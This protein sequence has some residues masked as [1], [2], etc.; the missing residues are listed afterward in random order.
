MWQRNE[1]DV[2]QFPLVINLLLL[3]VAMIVVRFSHQLKFIM[4]LR[5]NGHNILKPKKKRSRCTATIIEDGC[6]QYVPDFD[7]SNPPGYLQCIINDKFLVHHRCVLYYKKLGI[8]EF[9][10]YIPP[11]EKIASKWLIG[12]VERWSLFF[13]IGYNGDDDNYNMRFSMT[14]FPWVEVFVCMYVCTTI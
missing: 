5:R 14:G 9:V 1:R 8:H 2:P 12:G 10:Y 4:S 13:S 11:Q 3:R 6:K 7:R